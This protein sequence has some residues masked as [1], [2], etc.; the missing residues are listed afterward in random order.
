MKGIKRRRGRKWRR[1][2]RGIREG[3]FV[4]NVGEVVARCRGCW[5]EI[6]REVG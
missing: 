3:E 6:R 5:C 1:V 4:C 2:R